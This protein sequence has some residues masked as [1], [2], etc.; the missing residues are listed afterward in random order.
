MTQLFDKND[1]TFYHHIKNLFKKT[2]LSIPTVYQQ[3]IPG[4]VA[5]YRVE[6]RTEHPG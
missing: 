6:F 5:T 4:K 2:L 3:H 1:T